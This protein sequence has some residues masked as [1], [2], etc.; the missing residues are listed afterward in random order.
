MVLHR[1]VELAGILGNWLLLAVKLRSDKKETDL[2]ELI[3]SA[4]LQVRP[5]YCHDNV[6]A[7]FNQSH[8]PIDVSV[9]PPYRVE[10]NVDL[11]IR[12]VSTNK[13]SL[14]SSEKT[15]FRRE[16]LNKIV[17]CHSGLKLSASVSEPVLPRQR[18]LATRP[19]GLLGV[20]LKQELRRQ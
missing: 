5:R 3:Q 15:A 7:T 14:Q 11:E 9:W 19:S 8:T 1:P 6:L 13:S 10:F 12:A 17:P 20:L 4:E 16:N 18:D 2:L